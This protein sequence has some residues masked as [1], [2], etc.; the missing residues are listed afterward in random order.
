LRELR[1]GPSKCEC[2]YVF[3]TLDNSIAGAGIAGGSLTV[4]VL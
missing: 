4:A 1:P 3:A 2:P